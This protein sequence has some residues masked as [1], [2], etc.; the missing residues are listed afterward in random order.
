G[1][2]TTARDITERKRAE[3][4][5][6]ERTAYL[7]TLIQISPL[8]IV[9]LDTEERIQMSNPAF[10]KLFLYSRQELQGVNL[11]ELI[12]PPELMSEGEN[13]GRICLSVGSVQTASRRRR[14]DGTLVDVEIFG[15]PLVMAGEPR[16]LLGLYQDI[17]ERKRAEATMAERHRLATLVADVGVALTGGESL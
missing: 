5:L 2:V 3:K 16:G 14:K 8:G 13:L 9:V 6:E 17:T 7:N 1:V 11:N 12:V 4:A 15:V 10:E